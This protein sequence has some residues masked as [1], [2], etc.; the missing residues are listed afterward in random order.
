MKSNRLQ[1]IGDFTNRHPLLCSF[2]CLLVLGTILEFFG[3]YSGTAGSSSLD[4]GMENIILSAK[5][6]IFGIWIWIIPVFFISLILHSFSKRKGSHDASLPF[7]RRFILAFI[8]ALGIILL[9]SIGIVEDIPRPYSSN[10]MYLYPLAIFTSCFY[11]VVFG[12]FVGWQSKASRKGIIL[13]SIIVN[14]LMGVYLIFGHVINQI[15]F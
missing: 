12:T 8:P 10:P 6:S 13:Q 1:K 14:L 15:S 7:F 2:L 3:I 5:W 9:F 11:G 4:G